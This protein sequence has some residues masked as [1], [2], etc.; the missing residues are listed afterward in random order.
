ME[1]EGDICLWPASRQAADISPWKHEPTAHTALSC[2]DRQAS[3]ARRVCAFE[4]AESASMGA[5]GKLRGGAG[6]STS[7]V[8]FEPCGGRNS[9]L[10]ANARGRGHVE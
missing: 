8:G 7:H 3:D 4:S 2:T 10:E 6:G 5:D 1:Q 9:A